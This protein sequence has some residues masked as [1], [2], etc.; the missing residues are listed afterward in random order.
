M[1][2]QPLWDQISNPYM[3]NNTGGQSPPNSTWPAMGPRSWLGH[4][5]PWRTQVST[6]RCP[7]DSGAQSGNQ[8]ARLNYGGCIGDAVRGTHGGWG[9]ER[10]RGFFRA[11]YWHKF[12][13]MTDGSTNVI[14]VS[15]F[16][17]DAGIR[18]INAGA[19]IRVSGLAAQTIPAVCRAEV[20]DPLRPQFY[21]ADVQRS[22]VNQGTARGL[23]WNDGLPHFSG[24]NTL[25]AP[26]GPSCAGNDTGA[27]GIYTAGSRHPGGCHVVMGDGS[28]H[29]ISQNIDVGDQNR[30]PVSAVASDPERT[31]PGEPS[32]YGVWG[33]LGTRNMREAI[34]IEDAG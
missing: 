34:S 7:T 24:F 22:G 23:Q 25:M 8:R 11:R 5:E 2:Q 30:G 18:E 29:F 19:A 3:D 15:E 14:A 1:E 10:N 12:R 32:P 9:N 16:A 27:F 26:N 31:L 28:T 20:V 33:A 4:Y 6:Y 21:R 13:D 17:T